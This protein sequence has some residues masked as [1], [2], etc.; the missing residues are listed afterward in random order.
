MSIESYPSPNGVL[1]SLIWRKTAAGG[2]TSL[3]GYDNASQA[4]SYTPGQEQVY[5]NGILLVRG[6]DYT[7]TNGTSITGLAALTL[8]DF[9]QINC[10]NNFSLATLPAASITGVVSNAQL[11]NSSITINGS[12]VALGA[13]TTIDAL[14]SQSGNSGKYLTTNGTTASWSNVV[15]ALQTRVVSGTSDTPV[16]ADAGKIV[17]SS[18]GSATTITVPLNSSVAYAVGTQ[19]T[20]LQTGAGQLIVAG[21]SGVTVNATPGLKLRAQW[22]SATLI[23]R[24]TDTWVLIGDLTA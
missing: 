10:Y 2:E 15:Y 20:L 19:I 14:P 6:D 21:A 4:L 12:S 1:T 5:L 11:D 23:K 8:N 7:A 13:S 17:E 16:L 22:S 9:V 24:A 3:S 18:S